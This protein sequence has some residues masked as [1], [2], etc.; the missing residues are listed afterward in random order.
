MTTEDDRTVTPV[1][2][3]SCPLQ[4]GP[5]P[6]LAAANR[7]RPT[8]LPLPGATFAGP[9][10][11]AVSRRNPAAEYSAPLP[12]GSLARIPPVWFLSPYAVTLSNPLIT[13][14][15]TGRQ[16]VSLSENG[17]ERERNFVFDEPN[18][19][20]EGSCQNEVLGN[21]AGDD[22]ASD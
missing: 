3:D 17:V 9:A 15:A 6:V 22:Y 21:L 12:R 1:R 10:T 2:A 18:V 16:A 7:H 8:P 13:V 20:S 5:I 14:F 4:H 11:T 19:L